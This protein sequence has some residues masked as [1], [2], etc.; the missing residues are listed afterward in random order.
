MWFGSDGNGVPRQKRFL[1]NVKKGITPMTIWK[2]QDVG[3]SQ[4]ATKKLKALFDNHMYFEYPK[5]VDLI[6]RCI[7]LYSQEDSLN[8]DFFSGSAT[9]A[10]A[11]M[12]LNAEDGGHRKY[13]MVNLPEETDENSEA[14]KAGYKNICEIGK[15]RIRRAGEKILA[16]NKDKE[17]IE[18]LD[19]GFRVFRVDS[20]NM[21]DVAIE[22]NLL[23]QNFLDEYESNIKADRTD[24]DL[25]FA[26]LLAWGLPLDRKHESEDYHGFTIHSYNDGDLIACFDDNI[27]EEAIKYMAKKSL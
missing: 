2:Y 5:S 10:H 21:N 20:T 7:Q 11:V 3:H 6:K 22:P 14:Y 23:E 8:L 16:D 1:S 15:E 17:G 26:C 4:D 18:N 27:S 25:L 12:D 13:I 24:L 9:T 19:T